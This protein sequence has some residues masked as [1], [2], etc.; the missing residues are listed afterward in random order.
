MSPRPPLV[1][2][3]RFQRARDDKKSGWEPR[4]LYTMVEFMMVDKAQSSSTV[5]AVAEAIVVLAVVV[6]EVVVVVVVT[7]YLRTA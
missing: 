4:R 7:Q 6:V 5:V 3:Q 2:A 1:V